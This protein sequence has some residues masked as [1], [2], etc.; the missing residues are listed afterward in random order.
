MNEHTL[1]GELPWSQLDW[2]R[3]AASDQHVERKPICMVIQN[4]DDMLCAGG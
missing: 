4:A 2:I 3:S 1:C